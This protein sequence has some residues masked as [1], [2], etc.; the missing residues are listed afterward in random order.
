MTNEITR[1]CIGVPFEPATIVLWTSLVVALITAIIC[2]IAAVYRLSRGKSVVGV[3][4]LAIWVAVVSWLG[5]LSSLALATKQHLVFITQEP[6]LTRFWTIWLSQMMF[7]VTISIVICGI[8]GVIGLT[9]SLKWKEP[10]QSLAPYGAQRG[11]D[12]PIE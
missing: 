4:S 12:K 3:A 9:L 2:I 7:L 5:C 11:A 6:F 1:G 8:T 10:Q